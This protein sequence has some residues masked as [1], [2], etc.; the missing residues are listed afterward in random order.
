[1]F[2][3]SEH[4]LNLLFFAQVEIVNLIRDDDKFLKELFH[5]LTDTSPSFAEK[6]IDRVLFLKEL[7]TFSL[8]LQPQAREM[9]IKTLSQLGV[10]SAL[11]SL[12]QC[13]DPTIKSGAV[14]I[15]IYLVDY[16]PSMIREYAL[17]QEMTTTKVS[18]SWM[19]PRRMLINFFYFIPCSRTDTSSTSSSRK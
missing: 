19:E 13:S 18:G 14:D 3:F 1:M 2:Q 11:E 12:L 16:S 17:Q 5:Q 10:L 8:T 7:C 9:F 15:L 6:R 4:S